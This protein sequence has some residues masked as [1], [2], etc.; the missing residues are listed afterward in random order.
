MTHEGSL[1]E[2]DHLTTEDFAFY[3]SN[4]ERGPWT[5]IKKFEDNVYGLLNSTQEK[6]IEIGAEFEMKYLSF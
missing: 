2:S 6:I 5:L 1:P 3:G 4:S